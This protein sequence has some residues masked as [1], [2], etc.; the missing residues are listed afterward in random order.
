MKKINIIILIL[1]LSFSST[2][3]KKFVEGFDENP[4]SF[5]YTTPDLLIQGVVLQNQFFHKA[6]GMR[7]AMMWSNQATGADRQYIT[8]DNWNNATGDDFNG[9]WNEV[10][11]TMTQADLM[12]KVSND[13]N[14]QVLAGL[15]KLFKAWAGGQAAS[16]WGDV[17][18]SQ[19][20]DIE[21]YP[22]PA[23]DSQQQVF[24]NVQQVLDD[25]I[26]DLSSGNG[27]IPADKDIWFE[28]N[29]SKWIKIAH[30]LKARFYLHSKQYDLALQEAM[31]GPS[32][33]NDDLMA[34]F[35]SS[36]DQPWGRK[37]P[38]WQ[39]MRARDGYMDASDTYAKGL[40]SS[41]QNIKTRESGRKQYNYT[42]DNINYSTQGEQTGKFFGNMKLVT[43]GEML[44]IQSECIARDNTKTLTEALV[45]YNNYRSL[46]ETKYDTGG[47]GYPSTVK[48]T[49]YDT[50][51]FAQGGIE[52]HGSSS[53]SDPKKAFLREV[54]EER[55]IYFIGDYESFIDMCRSHNDS[56]IPSYMEVSDY[57]DQPLRFLYPQVE[58]DA[59]SNFPGE[60]D[61]TT[62]LPLYN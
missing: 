25:A 5:K 53:I 13:K 23:Y 29:A 60:I 61:V 9:P 16:L 49:A 40:L 37:N 33:P 28:G 15:A 6:D 18:F 21:N 19:A 52:N 55:Y 58:V 43:Y 20:N 8:L 42:G 31:L 44:L 3:C 59:N 32:A 30:G 2:S 47:Y 51:D 7:I 27:S 57:D 41:R 56:M 34:I 1:I 46:L 39:F 62:P 11:R 4:N 35:D 22:D 12:I 10:Y 14:I 24:D 54:F 17:P 26:A 45:P 38:T 50:S 36:P 48:Y